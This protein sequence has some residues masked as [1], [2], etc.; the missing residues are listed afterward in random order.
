MD[1]VDKLYK[2]ADAAHRGISRIADNPFAK[3]NLMERIEKRGI[4]NVALIDIEV[5]ENYV[6]DDHAIEG[7]TRNWVNTALLQIRSAH[8]A[9]ERT[10]QAT[11]NKPE[12]LVSVEIELLDHEAAAI[13]KEIENFKTCSK[14]IGKPETIVRALDDI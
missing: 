7:F 13:R 8:N 3:I 12:G 6:G 9:E 2:A 11:I 4:W 10:Y 1:L 5:P 14:R